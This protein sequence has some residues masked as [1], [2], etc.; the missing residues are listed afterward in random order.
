MAN[1]VQPCMWCD[2]LQKLMVWIETHSYG[3][4]KSIIGGVEVDWKDIL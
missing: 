1:L 3:L 4:Y 2:Q